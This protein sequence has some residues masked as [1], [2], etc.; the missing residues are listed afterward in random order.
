MAMA[1]AHMLQVR[2]YLVGLCHQQPVLQK[3]QS[4]GQ[5][6]LFLSTAAVRASP[7]KP[8]ARRVF[9]SSDIASAINSPT[10]GVLAWYAAAAL[11]Y[12]AL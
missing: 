7:A 1:T 6:A 4:G 2:G 11:L 3:V 12:V 9:A 10:H 5:S 8:I